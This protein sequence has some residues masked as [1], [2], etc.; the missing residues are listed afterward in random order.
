MVNMSGLSK[1]LSGYSRALAVRLAVFLTVCIFAAAAGI[2]GGRKVFAEQETWSGAEEDSFRIFEVTDDI[3]ARM[4]GNTWQEGCPVPPGDLRYLK[5]LC[6]DIDGETHEG[7]IIVNYH[8]AEEVLEIFRKLYEAAYPVE[9]IRLADEYGG[10]DELSMEDNN[11]SAFNFRLITGSSVISKHALGLAVDINPLYNPYVR[12]LDDGMLLEPATAGGYLDRTA[13]FP[14]KIREDDL[15]C[16]LFSEYGFE[17]GGYW[18][19]CKDYQHFEVPDWQIREW[20]P[21]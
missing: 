9:K 3:F 6:V 14:Y 13:E 11:T 19:S 2:P 15:C 10:V 21:Y 12:Y 7:E 4:E 8:I 17:W 1:T 20:Y 5:V 18:T 16:R